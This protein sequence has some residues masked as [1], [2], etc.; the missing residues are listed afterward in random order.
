MTHGPRRLRR[1]EAGVTSY[2]AGSRR[3]PAKLIRLSI[4]TISTAGSTKLR[5]AG[6]SS[7]PPGGPANGALAAQP[8]ARI[9]PP[10][11]IAASARVIFR[12]KLH[13]PC[14]SYVAT[15]P[16][17]G[18]SSAPS[19]WERDRPSLALWAFAV[20]LTTAPAARQAFPDTIYVNGHVI[21]MWADRPVVQA[22]AIQRRPVR[23]GRQHGRDSR[24][25]GPVDPA[26]RSRRQDRRPRP[27]GQSHASGHGGAQRAGRARSGHAIDRGRSGLRAAARRD[28]A[29][30]PGDPCA[31]GVLDAAGRTPLSDARRARPGGASA[32]RDHRQRL[33]GVAELAGARRRSASRATRRSQPMAASARTTRANRRA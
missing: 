9:A 18:L 19:T 31:Q 14:H 27:P 4:A 7:E 3:R 8:V 6:R 26:H 32:R 25:C 10:T 33:C 1:I 5:S 29:A 22:I 28:V 11:T 15:G 17:R 24:P 12:E 30:G 20:L 23:R 2:A 21:T 16:E 13:Q